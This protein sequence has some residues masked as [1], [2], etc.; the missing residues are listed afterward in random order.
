VADIFI[1]LCAFL[2]G[3]GDSR[4]RVFVLDGQGEASMARIYTLAGRRDN[5]A[6]R[7]DPR[8][9]GFLLESDAIG[10]GEI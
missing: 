2:R 5:H 6:S 10:R 7:R 9:L 1:S 3:D 8:V 4:H